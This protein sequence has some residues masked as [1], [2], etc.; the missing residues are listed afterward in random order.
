MSTTPAAATTT[1][2]DESPTKT[3]TEDSHPTDNSD[4]PPV[5]QPPSST[6]VDASPKDVDDELK[7]SVNSDSGGSVTDTQKKIRR[8]ERFGLP[9]QLSE[10]E[11]R[12][13]RSERFGISSGPQVSDEV[14]KSEDLKRKARGERFGTAQSA[15]SAD[16]ADD[17][18]KKKA[19]LARFAPVSAAVSQQDEDKKKARALR[20]SQ[21]S[22][23]ITQ[24]N[25]KGNIEPKPAIAGKAGG[26]I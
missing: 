7:D 6:D 8:A 1:H 18:A 21:T 9:V 16:S 17:E 14:K 2:A 23:S 19:R 12:N 26:G 10:S 5:Q 3:L 15:P 13:S 22:A 24:A 4:S 25:G 11:K 20:F